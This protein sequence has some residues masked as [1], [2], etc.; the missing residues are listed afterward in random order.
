MYN[1]RSRIFA[2]DYFRER[3]NLMLSNMKKT[4][5]LLLVLAACAAPAHAEET[6]KE[7]PKLADGELFVSD[8]I[9]KD[10]K[11]LYQALDAH[12]DWEHD[13]EAK[14]PGFV[15]TA[16]IPAADNLQGEKELKSIKKVSKAEEK[17]A[18][19]QR[20][21]SGPSYKG[22]LVLYAAMNTDGKD[23]N[24]AIT[25]VER[26]GRLLNVT[27]AVQDP[28]HTQTGKEDLYQE[29]VVFLPLKQLPEFGSL[30]VRFCDTTGHALEDLDVALVP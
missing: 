16:F 17:I 2:A 15:G 28:K 3:M 4:A 19:V 8:Q 21:Y 10:G 29:S 24:L 27:V 22:K 20:T 11:V 18:A 7:A 26:F 14:V 9:V 6:V 25:K 1:S 13:A 30:R 23:G 12:T 5:A